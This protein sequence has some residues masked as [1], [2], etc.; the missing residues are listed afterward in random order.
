M[1]CER[2]FPRGVLCRELLPLLVMLLLLLR[3]GILASRAG[4][5][6]VLLG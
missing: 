5:M 1:Q 3:V 6:V 4:I 2:P